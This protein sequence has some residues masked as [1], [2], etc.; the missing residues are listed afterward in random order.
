MTG[1]YY[2]AVD[3]ADIAKQLDAAEASAQTPTETNNESGNYDDS[4]YFSV[5]VI[6]QALQVWNLE[7]VPIG[8]TD[9][10]NAL[11]EPT[12]GNLGALS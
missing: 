5:Q 4:G 10:K 12:Y 3:L 2:T 8:S 1:P 11:D 9:A 7:L 6:T